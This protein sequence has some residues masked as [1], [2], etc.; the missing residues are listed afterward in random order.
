MIIK[1]RHTILIEKHPYYESLNKK[2]M[3]DIRLLE[4]FPP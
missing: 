3:E 4:F 2:L 1:E